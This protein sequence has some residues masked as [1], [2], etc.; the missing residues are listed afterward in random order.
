M[1]CS[2]HSSSTTAPLPSIAQPIVFGTVARFLG[3]KQNKNAPQATHQW[4]VYVRGAQGLDITHFVSRVVFALHPS[5]DVPERTLTAPPFEVHESGWGEFEIGITVHFLEDLAP[6]IA[7]KHWLKLYTDG[8]KGSQQPMKNKPL[9][10][11]LY[12]EIVFDAPPAKLRAALLEGGAEA[13]L[14]SAASN[15][16]QRSLWTRFSESA[17]VQKV[18]AAHE[19]VRRELASLHRRVAVLYNATSA[20]VGSKVPDRFAHTPVPLEA[21]LVRKPAAQKLKRG[22]V[23][24]ASAAADGGAPAAKN[25]GGRPRGSGKKSG[26]RQKR[27]TQ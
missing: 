15:P 25:K 3:R 27:A 17:D 6:P 23:D 9:T 8:A 24:S 13:T 16:S 21:L 22:R 20:V 4:S 26:K 18:Q 14:A 11:E 10:S 19:Y 1:Q 5:F 7:T 12:D 2:G